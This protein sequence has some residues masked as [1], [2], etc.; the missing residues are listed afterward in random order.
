[1]PA[2][3]HRDFLWRVSV[4]AFRLTASALWALGAGV[5][6][7]R[8][9]RSDR[10]EREPLVTVSANSGTGSNPRLPRACFPARVNLCRFADDHAVSTAAT[11]ALGTDYAL[12]MRE[13]AHRLFAWANQLPPFATTG[14]RRSACWRATD[15]STVAAAVL[16]VVASVAFGGADDDRRIPLMFA[17]TFE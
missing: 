9:G 3:P 10:H 6:W 2:L 4:R 17:A 5:E 11:L 14:C 8:L 15:F 13:H 1:M 12:K 7:S 16:F